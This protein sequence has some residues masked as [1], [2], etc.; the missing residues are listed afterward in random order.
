MTV[1]QQHSPAC[2]A[3]CH[4][5]DAV[6]VALPRC[7]GFAPLRG[8]AWPQ[9]HTHHSQQPHSDVHSTLLGLKAGHREGAVSAN[10]VYGKQLYAF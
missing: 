5:L 10:S 2:T 7:G 9:T 8:P 6:V 1:L 4:L 3:V